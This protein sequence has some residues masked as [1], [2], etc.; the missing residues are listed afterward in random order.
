MSVMEDP[1]GG[2]KAQGAETVP[3]APRVPG[4]PGGPGV[5]GV[6]GV[7]GALG[8]PGAPGGP[9]VLWGSG[10]PG[11]PGAPCVPGVP[12]R[13]P[14]RATAPPPPSPSGRL[15]GPARGGAAVV[16]VR[17]ALGPYLALV[18]E[19]PAAV[20]LTEGHLRVGLGGAAQAT[21]AIGGIPAEERPDAGGRGAE[22][23]NYGRASG[24]HAD[25]T[26][27]ACADVLYGAGGPGHA[28]R[29][30]LRYP[31]CLLVTVRD[32]DGGGRCVALA[33]GGGA[34]VA[35]TAAG[36]PPISGREHALIASALHAWLEAGLPLSALASAEWSFPWPGREPADEAPGAQGARWAG[37]VLSPLSPLSLL[38]PLA[39]KAI[40]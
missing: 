30:L 19:S 38:P 29:V 24:E 26:T 40:W 7:P 21:G 27:P 18:T 12:G 31:G 11:V 39:A 22:G 23:G 10:V 6:P 36:G 1:A 35:V 25:A 8:V 13:K 16:V 34:P 37:V 14:V 15:Q 9:G 32:A 2:V 5:P 28:A 4:V 17:S 33:R 20:P 3:G